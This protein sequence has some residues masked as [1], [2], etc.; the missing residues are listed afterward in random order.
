MHYVAISYVATFFIKNC[1]IEIMNKLFILIVILLIYPLAILATDK[2]EINSASLQQLEGM[3]GIGPVL[4]QRIIDARPFSSV[5]DLLRV[6][7]IGDK[8]LQK[9]KD[10]GLA[11]VTGQ[12]QPV[13]QPANQTQT[14]TTN[15][16]A[17]AATPMPATTP[18]ASPIMYPGGVVLNE[19]MP[20]PSGPDETNEWIEL[21]NSNTFDVDLSG[22]KLQDTDGTVTTYAFLQNTKILANQYL[23]LTRPTTNIILNNDQDGLHLMTPDGKTVSAVSYTNA[24]RTQSYNN[25]ADDWQWSTT[26]TPGRINNITA[27]IATAPQK[28]LPKTQ[29]TANSKKVSATTAA[30]SEP[31]NI[32]T[33]IP[34]DNQNN[35]AS[36]PWLL[37]FAAITITLI[38][39]VLVWFIKIKLFKKDVGSQSF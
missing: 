15:Q 13:N 36:N 37:L 16:P 3:T 6:K 12:P 39:G 32:N 38:A 22:W 1:I 18:Q 11:Y 26:L 21:Y 31:V 20:A 24:I 8:T 25:T 28:A 10:Q 30:V 35:T 17:P 23:V 5:D 19:I 29:K 4:A 7:G 9:I 14:T 27:T 34:P 2:I 33:E